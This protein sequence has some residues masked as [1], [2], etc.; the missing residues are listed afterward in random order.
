MTDL[1]FETV[2]ILVGFSKMVFCMLKGRPWFILII[3]TKHRNIAFEPGSEL[4][5]IKRIKLIGY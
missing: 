4:L 3:T 5:L 2:G 1:F